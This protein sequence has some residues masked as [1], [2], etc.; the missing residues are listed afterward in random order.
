[1]AFG[2]SLIEAMRVGEDHAS[3]WVAENAAAGNGLPQKATSM[4]LLNMVGARLEQGLPGGVRAV[5]GQHPLGRFITGALGVA[6]FQGDADTLLY[7]PGDILFGRSNWR[8]GYYE[9]DRFQGDVQFSA[10]YALWHFNA[11]AEIYAYERERAAGVRAAIAYE[12]AGKAARTAAMGAPLWDRVWEEPFTAHS[13][14]GLVPLG[15]EGDPVALDRA[16]TDRVE[17]L[18]VVGP[19]EDGVVPNVLKGHFQTYGV[20]FKSLVPIVPNIFLAH[21]WE[22]L[23]I[24]LV[25]FT[26]DPARRNEHGEQTHAYP[27]DQFYADIWQA[28]SGRPYQPPRPDGGEA[29]KFAQLLPMVFETHEHVDPV[30][31]AITHRRA[32]GCRIIPPTAHYEVLRTWYL[33]RVRYVST[34][35]VPTA[36]QARL[37]IR[38]FDGWK[39]LRS[40]LPETVSE[41]ATGNVIGDADDYSIQLDL[42]VAR[43]GTLVS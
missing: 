41:D 19:R 33:G 43:K 22:Q 29:F 31:N 7:S 17:L 5:V 25:E 2:G 18:G 1:M 10:A 36:E 13:L 15:L 16:S 28:H 37:G 35:G 42:D 32:W 38:I 30:W 21:E 34:V 6:S 23:A 26:V 11:E 4:P 12:P 40:A 24:S 14:A 8:P 20:R 3:S 27:Y 39:A 9:V